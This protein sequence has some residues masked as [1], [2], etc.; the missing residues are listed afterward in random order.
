MVKRRTETLWGD[1]GKK[2]RSFQESETGSN[3]SYWSV[4][5][6]ICNISSLIHSSTD[7]A[8]DKNQY[9]PTY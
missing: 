8:P 7:L 5:L 9:A 1:E 4:Y 6:P 3:E 2:T